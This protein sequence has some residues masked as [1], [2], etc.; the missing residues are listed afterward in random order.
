M[1]GVPG[2]Q[3][4]CDHCDVGYSHI[5]DH[6]TACSHRCSFC[7]ANTPCV[8][9]GTCVQCS[10]CKGFFRNME[11]YRRHLRTY[12]DRTRVTLC[13]L[14]GR[15]D[16]CNEWMTK[17]LLQRHKCGGQKHCKICKRQ[18]DE[19]HKCYVQIKPKHK[20]D[21][22]DRKRPLQMY[23]YFDFEC[24]QE[25]GIHVPNLCVAHRV[26]HC[27][28]RLPINEPCKRCESLWTPAARVSRPQHPKRF[29]GLA[30]GHYP[31]RPRTM[32]D[33]K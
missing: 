17:K 31:S 24:T 30:A 20:D 29:H 2:Y 25:N 3:N 18:V 12:S 1:P 21:V 10:I 28:D 13:D 33:G 7:L 6:R 15:C 23:I 32:C 19:D 22:K 8:P 16:R 14:M 5:E 11:C 27:C 9:D 26:C 4:Y